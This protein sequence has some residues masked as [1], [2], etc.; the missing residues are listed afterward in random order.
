MNPISLKIIFTDETE[1]D[2]TA[3]AADLIA[4]EERFDMSVASLE[5]NVRMTHLFFIAW[6]ATKRAGETKDEFEKWVE[7]VNMV[8]VAEAKK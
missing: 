1:K 6:H 5:K 3:V 2:V 4:F 7:S 8:T